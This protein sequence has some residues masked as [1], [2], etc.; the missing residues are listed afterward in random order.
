MSMSEYTPLRLKAAKVKADQL[1]ATGAKIV[2]TT[3]HNCVDALTDVIRHYKLGMKVAQLVNLVSSALVIEE[4][5]A[6]PE[7]IVAAVE[8]LPL[9]KYKILVVDDEPDIL[10]FISTVLEDQG[11]TAVRASD[12]EQALE[13]ALKEKPDLITLDLSM[14]GKNGGFVFEELRKN[15]ELSSIKVCI[16]T[17]KPE[18]RRLIY[19]RPVR[20]PEGYLDKPVNEET[21]LMNV[22]KILETP[23]EGKKAH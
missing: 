8:A 13:L 4:K 22:R 21:L 19:D 1:K 11:A 6:V 3:C 2:V 10:T 15:P 18:L 17:G 5:V 7:K 12:A 20:P 9:Q 23:H 16:I 14:P